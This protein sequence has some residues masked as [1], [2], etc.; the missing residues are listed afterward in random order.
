MVALATSR[1]HPGNMLTGATSHDVPA[2]ML[3]Y[4]E[5]KS[6]I[7]GDADPVSDRL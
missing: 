2:R 3:P 5:W 4:F 7:N 6:S 1:T